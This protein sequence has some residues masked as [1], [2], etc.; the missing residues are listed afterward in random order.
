MYKNRVSVSKGSEFTQAHT[1]SITEDGNQSKRKTENE[2][3]RREREKN[4]DGKMTNNHTD[5]M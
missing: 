4:I 2:R 3:K 1:Q 5:T